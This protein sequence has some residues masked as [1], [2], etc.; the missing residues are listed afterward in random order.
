MSWS[1][2]YALGLLAGLMLGLIFG[3]SIGRFI[4]ERAHASPCNMEDVLH[5]GDTRIHPP[6]VYQDLRVY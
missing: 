4:C 6:G 3:A 5:V 1:A 2:T